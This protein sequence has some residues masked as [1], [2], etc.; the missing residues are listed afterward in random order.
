[1]GHHS[2]QYSRASASLHRNLLQNLK[3]V[4]FI[5]H[6]LT[7]QQTVVKVQTPQSH[8]RYNSVFYGC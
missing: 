8:E 5:L 6:V 2:E 7:I 1:M 3:H 4:K